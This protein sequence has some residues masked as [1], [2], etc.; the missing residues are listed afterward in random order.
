[1]YSDLKK[2]ISNLNVLKIIFLFSAVSFILFLIVIF[3]SATS[4]ITLFSESGDTLLKFSIV[5]IL[6]LTIFFDYFAIK[7]FFRTRVLLKISTY[8]DR[9]L[10]VLSYGLYGKANKVNFERP[11]IFKD[12]SAKTYLYRKCIVGIANSGFIVSKEFKSSNVSGLI[13]TLKDEKFHFYGDGVILDSMIYENIIDFS[14]YRANSSTISNFSS[15][16]SNREMEEKIRSSNVLNAINQIKSAYN[17]NICIS[18]MDDT[19][20]IIIEGE[21]LQSNFND[22]NVMKLIEQTKSIMSLYDALI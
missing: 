12:S 13:I 16:F 9:R 10:G 5:A 17:K 1:M 3:L 11:K 7:I 2:E 4:G 18:F 6:V 20:Y 19:V 21:K 22:E 15:Y 14:E 8:A